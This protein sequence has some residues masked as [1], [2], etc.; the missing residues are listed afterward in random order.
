MIAIVTVLAA[1][2]LGFFVRNRLAAATAYAVAYLWAFTFQTLYLLLDSLGGG[3]APAFEV[4]EFPLDYGVVTLAVFA[5]GFF[6]RPLGGALL[7]SFSDRYGRRTALTL[8]V[9]LMAGGSLLIAVAPTYATIGVAAPLLLVLA[10]AVQ[11]LSAGGE[12]AAMSTYVIEIAPP[13][14]RGRYASAIY[15]STTAGTL[16]ALGVAATLRVWLTPAELQTWGWRI[17][18]AL[19]GVLGL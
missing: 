16:L 14:R 4:D 12:V 11:G 8:S 6:F 5:V 10:R 18:S 17:P 13:D 1:L 19:G 7:G 3:S 15:A 9:L 2:P